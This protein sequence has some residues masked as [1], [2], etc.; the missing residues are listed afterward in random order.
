[1][2]ARSLLTKAFPDSPRLRSELETAINTIDDVVEQATALKAQ[3]DTLSAG[4]ES[5]DFQ[6]LSGLL[7]AVAGLPNRV[8]A[9]EFT[10]TDVANIR[11]IDGADPAS[12]VSRGGAY[13]VFVAYGGKGIT[14]ARPTVPSTVVAIYFDTTLAANGK[15]IFN[16][17][18]AGWVDSSGASV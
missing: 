15:P 4:L 18:G 5:G 1:V 6:P 3:L 11:P 17:K 10:G 16:F 2:I 8:G 14:S 13:T 12:L 7:T 9:V